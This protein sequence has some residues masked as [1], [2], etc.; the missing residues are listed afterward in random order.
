MAEP[1]D[2]RAGP[3]GRRPDVTVLLAVLLPLLTASALL[4]R[5]EEPAPR[6]APPVEAPL[7][8]ATLVCPGGEDPVQV[9]AGAEQGGTVDLAQGRR[10][11]EVEVAAGRT[12][13]A[14]A[15]PRP[16]VVT[17]EGDAASGLLA[18]RASGTASRE[19]RPPAFDEWFTGVGAG[20]EHSSV[21]ELTNPD[22]GP[23]VVDVTVHGRRGPVAAPRLRGVAVP[24]R[25]T[26]RLD[27]ARLLPRRDELA[28]HVEVGRG[29]VSA[30]V[31]DRT[32][33][34]GREA[35][36]E[37][38]LGAQVPARTHLLLG[39]PPG[40]G[41]R[42]L[43]VANPGETE[44]RAAVELVTPESVFAAVD[45]EELVVPPGAVARLR[46]ASVLR[47]ENARDAIGLRVVSTGPVTATLRSRAGGDLTNTVPV[48]GTD[49][50]TAALL[51]AGPKR[52][53]LAGAAT[54]GVARVVARDARGRVLA[55]QQVQV[56]PER[57]HET[58][59]PDGTALVTVEP[60]GTAVAGSVLLEDGGA[61]VVRLQPVLR[62]GL[63]ADVRPGPT[64]RS[65]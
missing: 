61:T 46:V 26:V 35:R 65:G 11:R 45:T 4:V 56:A 64:Y 24:G 38:Q 52:L 13:T 58:G 16:V 49:G 17:A 28:L 25:R 2:R 15:R 51:P 34:I 3:V 10:T 29:R 33:R 23:A 12:T 8:V 22:A 32:D 1:R 19:C 9:A 59:L 5:T 42:V 39:L 27:L 57:G 50:A 43:V 47:A 18:G 60:D 7:S 21:L 62:T 36:S 31:L 14:R 20:A 44:V 54:E 55:E 30:S 6:G 41:P 63:V 48:A 53:L 40:P 37:D